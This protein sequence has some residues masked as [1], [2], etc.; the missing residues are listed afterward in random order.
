MR[1]LATMG[2]LSALAS[3]ALAGDGPERQPAPAKVERR[4]DGGLI[5]KVPPLVVEG[6][7]QR[8]QAFFVLPRPEVKY[9][10]PELQ[11]PAPPPAPVR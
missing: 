1:L 3:P 10:W 7:V 8:P 2:L 9:E 5:Y 11:R 6:K 4:A